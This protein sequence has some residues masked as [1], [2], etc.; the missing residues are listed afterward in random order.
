M[1]HLYI[2]AGPNGA[3]KT[4]ASLTVL[5]EMLNCY[6]FVNADEIAKGLSPFAPESVALQSGRLMLQRIEELLSKEVDFAIETTLA[7]RSYVNLVQQ[8]RQK[9]YLV[10]LLYFWLPS[11]Q[12]A[13]ERVLKRV[14]EGGH[15]IPADVIERR[16]IHGLKNLALFL[17]IMN[18][19][20]VYNNESIPAMLIAKGGLESQSEII[21]FEIWTKIKP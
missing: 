20:Y 19:W 3:G 14:S 15:N 2:I 17:P 18:R 1:R 16:Y 5:P 21:N 9:G 12:M 8:A 4:T 13:K 7:T 6:Q 10:T 11:A